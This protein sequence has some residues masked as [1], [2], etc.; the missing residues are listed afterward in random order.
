MLAKFFRCSA[1]PPR[2]RQ[3]H[4]VVLP[5]LPFSDTNFPIPQ[6]V[7]FRFFFTGKGLFSPE[8][9]E[10]SSFFLR[11][12]FF[13]KTLLGGFDGSNLVRQGGAEEASVRVSQARSFLIPLWFFLTCLLQSLTNGACDQ[14][15]GFGLRL[16][17]VL[18]PLPYPFLPDPHNLT[19][20]PRLGRARTFCPSFNPGCPLRPSLFP[21]LLLL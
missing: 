11:R 16:F 4:L 13:P 18:T 7:G 17:Q 9:E 12:V 3:F 14:P 20:S 5:P 15:P 10:V 2:C 19:F 21:R 8:E 1:N 6:P